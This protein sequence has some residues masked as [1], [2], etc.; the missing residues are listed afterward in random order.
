MTA[1]A[2]STTQDP[3]GAIVPVAAALDAH[4][5]LR[6]EATAL[7]SIRPNGTSVRTTYAQLRSECDRIAH[8][9]IS[10][11]ITRGMRT[12][13]MVRPGLEFFALTF[14]LF[15]IGAVVVLVDPGLGPLRL[16]RCLAETA[17]TAFI[18]IAKAQI[19]RCVLGWARAS[20]RIVITVGPRFGWS[21]E[22][23][24]R[25]RARAPSDQFHA[26]ASTADELA[27]IL[28]TSGATGAPKGALYT[29]GIFA[30]QIA[31]LRTL[32]RIEPGEVDVAT[33][34][35]FALFD[36]ALGVTALLPAMDYTRPGRVDGRHL[37]ELIERHNATSVF[38]SPAVLRQLAAAL[39]ANG[40][41][42]PRLRRILSA[43]APAEP[44]TLAIIA[45]H[46]A[47]GAQIHTPYGA[48]E[49]L[50]VASIGSAEILADTRQATGAGRGTCVG[51]PVPGIEVAVIRLSDEPIAKW[52][53]TLRVAEGVVGEIAVKGP[54]VTRG[55]Y[56]QPRATALAK[57]TDRDGIWHR[58]GDT[59]Y[60]DAQGRLWFCGR[61]SERVRTPR[62]TLYT[63]QCEGIFNTHPDVARSALVGIGGPGAARP[64]LVF[65]LHARS[66]RRG[67]AQIC[68]ELRALGAA[69]EP[70]RDIEQLLVHRGLPVD[71]RHNSKIA[72][73]A[74]QVWAQRK[75]K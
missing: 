23:L 3:A 75:L 34:P 21:G 63:E 60:L 24:A 49:A 69:H 36:A 46:L 53:D 50:P 28:Y 65:E 37:L 57:I 58:M 47:A 62:G 19:A 31:L 61:K 56:G 30:Q 66:R 67:L 33:F 54:I 44:K 73:S 14:A 40:E 48:T 18:G 11:G 35:L 20:V 26:A 45:R 15:K 10:A 29:H 1:S 52:S 6:P 39:A 38:A 9:L 64:A 41:P 55:Y 13:V 25:L 5:A 68:R 74:L 22:T 7:I 4:A 16:K 43:G 32:Y 70:T 42:L 2:A 72:R 71:R 8:G 12:V 51:R 59:G 27:A 17:P